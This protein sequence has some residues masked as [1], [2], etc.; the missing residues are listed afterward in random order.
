MKIYGIPDNKDCCDARA[1]LSE[2]GAEYE[3]VDI[4]EGEENLKE[5]LTLR[6]RSDGFTGF[7]R[8][9]N[10]GIPCYLLDD[11]TVT[12]DTD[13]VV[14]ISHTIWTQSVTGVLIKDGKVL[15]GRHTYG[16]GKGKL[17]VPGGYMSEG[18][19]PQE[20]LVREYEEETGVIVKPLD[21]IGIRFNQHDWYVAFSLEYIGGTASAHDEENS[22]VVWI[23]VD[24]AL[25]RDDVPDLTK[26]LIKSA[27]S[28]HDPLTL[29]DYYSSNEK[30]GIPSLYARM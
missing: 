27:L 18:E 2:A 22:E 20:A 26:L 23:D 6:D 5:F 14:G 24:E 9:G 4:T 12:F 7:K 16:A 10:I 15:L 13:R 17:I 1:R 29:K 8:C 25:T 21:I 30:H 19:T 3:F 11:G 28:D